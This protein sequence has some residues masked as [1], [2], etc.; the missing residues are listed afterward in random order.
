MGVVQEVITL[1]NAVD[2]GN[3]RR[4]IL[5]EPEIRAAMVTAMVDT[6]AMTLVIRV[7]L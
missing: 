6:G 5:K 7:C 2:V 1:K 3:C 4:G